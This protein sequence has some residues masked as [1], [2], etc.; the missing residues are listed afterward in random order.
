MPS[1]SDVGAA[2]DDDSRLTD[3]RDPNAHAASHL[4]EGD[5]ELFDQSLNTTS[6]VTFNSID[7]GTLTAT[8]LEGLSEIALKDNLLND[9][10]ISAGEDVLTDDRRYQLPDADGTLA[11]TSDI[12]DP[13][14]ATPQA[15]G[16][17]AAGT[18]DDY[19]RGDHIH[20]A[21][22]LNDL[23]NVSAATPSDND[24]LV[25]DTA[26]STWVAEAPAAGGIASDT[27]GITGASAITNIVA[28]SQADYDDI[29]SPDAATLFLITDP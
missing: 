10:I 14:T 25:Y 6:A 19:S 28:I 11:L 15:L 21:P 24:V 22:A 18:S 5:D 12:P 7:V 2:A 3:T 20:A 9:V 17:A 23:S 29:V 1:A 13:S 16:T 4:P 26:T 27:T 8:S